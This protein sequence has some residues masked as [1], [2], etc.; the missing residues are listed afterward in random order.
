MRK[1]GRIKESRGETQFKDSQGV[2]RSLKDA[3]MSHKVDAVKW[4]NSTGRNYG[5]RA[6]EV[7]K[8]MRDSSNYEL[9]YFKI[10]RSNGGKLPDRYLPPLK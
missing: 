5:A 7:R 10:N 8:W 2:W 9:D 4:C 1:E 3:D 6:P